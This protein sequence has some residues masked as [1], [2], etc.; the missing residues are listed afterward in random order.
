MNYNEHGLRVEYVEYT[1]QKGDSLYMIA[2]RFNTTV[3]ELS[4]INMLTSNTIF[5]GQ[6]LLVPKNSADTADYYFEN[7]VVQQNDTVKK[8]ADELGVDPILI[9]L[10]NDFATYKIVPGQTLKIPR[11][12]AYIVKPNDS[13]DSILKSTNRTAEQILRANASTW[14]KT[15]T[16]IYL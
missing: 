12:N 14:F 16:K 13:V 2:E 10:Y 8:I 1:V 6:V 3:S 15:G 9:G 7:Y 4:D 5:P 11:N